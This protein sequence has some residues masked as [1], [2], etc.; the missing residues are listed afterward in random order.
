[1]R[2]LIASVFIIASLVVS[3]Q[4]ND[5]HSGESEIFKTPDELLFEPFE[6]KPGGYRAYIECSNGFL[7]RKIPAAV[8]KKVGFDSAEAVDLS[9]AALTVQ[10]IDAGT[11]RVRVGVTTF[12]E[13]RQDAPTISEMIAWNN[14]LS[15]FGYG[16]TNSA[17]E[18]QW[19]Q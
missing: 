8:L 18:Y 14:Y 12:G 4:T 16:V 1:M 19:T 15:L 17:G 5:I 13:C 3:A 7:K 6:Y 2:T 11:Y 10:K 9:A